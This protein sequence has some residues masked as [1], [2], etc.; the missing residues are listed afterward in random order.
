MN[1][2][3][4]KQEPIIT[5]VNKKKD[6]IIVEEKLNTLNA[7]ENSY[8]EGDWDLSSQTSTS[9]ASSSILQHFNSSLSSL[10]SNRMPLTLKFVL[11]LVLIVFTLII[12]TAIIS[13]VLI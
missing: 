10:H 5:T 12:L 1:H 3:V 13:L 9:S 4:T 8:S 7:N 6:D 11:Q 2:E